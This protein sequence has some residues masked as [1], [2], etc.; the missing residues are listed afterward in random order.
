MKLTAVETPEKDVCKMT[1]AA[2]AAE[3]DAA[4]Q[5][6]Y[7]RTRAGITL[8]GF[9]RGEATRAAVEAAKGES[10]FWYDAINE[11]MAREVPPLYE[12]ALTEH[13]LS[14]VTDPVYDLVRADAA[15]GFTATATVCLEPEITVRRYTGFTARQKANPVT[16][17][18]VDHFIGRR[19]EALAEL[20]PHKG[21]AVR[22]NVV[23]LTYVGFTDQGPFAGGQGTNA[24]ITLGDGRMIPGF[25]EAILGHR[26]G[27]AFEIHVTFP[28]QYADAALAGKPAVFRAKLEDVCVRRL[29]ALNADF[30]QK[31]GH[32]DSIE[33]YRAEVRRHLEE[34]KRQNAEQL[35]RGAVLRQ[36]S[37]ETEGTLSTLLTDQQYLEELQQFQQELTRYRKKLETYLAETHQ[38]QDQLKAQ[39]REQ[40]ARQVRTHLALLRIARL[41]HLEPTDAEVDAE[42]AARAAR[43][44]QTPEAYLAETESRRSVRRQL[45]AARAADFVAA[46]STIL[47]E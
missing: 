13:A 3:L 11:L 22:G 15:E 42:A 29:P 21:P 10:Y 31:A 45:C 20:V 37:E 19:R 36:L 17:R 18:E 25:E 40:A 34:L 4:A 26:A 23:H 24:A 7:E 2:S 47:V 1:F 44:H 39:L 12:Q 43:A 14:P 41:E 35:A 16:E 5:A 28:A 9:A 30:A 32:A 27:D 33:A 8:E 6:V 46:H 38:T